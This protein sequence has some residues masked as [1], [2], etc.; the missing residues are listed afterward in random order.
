[1]YVGQKSNALIGLYVGVASLLLLTGA[2]FAVGSY[3]IGLSKGKVAAYYLSQ[4]V[5]IAFIFIAV[6]LLV[7]RA[8][9]LI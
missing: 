9:S 6:V 5:G 1:M 7:L 4:F 8:A 3:F 2:A